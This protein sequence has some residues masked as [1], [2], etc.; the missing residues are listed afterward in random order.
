MASDLSSGEYYCLLADEAGRTELLPLRG[1]SLFN[2]VTDLETE[3]GFCGVICFVKNGIFPIAYGTNGDHVYDWRALINDAIGDKTDDLSTAVTDT[4]SV[5]EPNEKTDEPKKD[6]D[7]ADPPKPTEPIK[8]AEAAV[9]IPLEPPVTGGQVPVKKEKYDDE[10]LAVKNYYKDIDDEPNEPDVDRADAQAESG[11]KTKIQADGTDAQEDDDAQ[12]V[13]AEL[14]KDPDGYYLSVKTELDE[15]FQK[16][17]RDETL[18]EAFPYSEWVKI[19]E[20]GTH[21]LVGVLYDDWKAKYVCY[22]VEAED[23][24]APPD[25]LKD[26]CVFIPVTVTDESKGYFVIFQSAASGEC[27]KPESL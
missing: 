19:E 27:I 14:A 26:V 4:A 18:K 17:P 24:N 25:E 5:K 8:T 20:N 21:Q 13:R 10:T 7:P 12:N 11:D 6:V 23:P 22:A 15:L 3:H 1:K 2:I 16:Y 9:V